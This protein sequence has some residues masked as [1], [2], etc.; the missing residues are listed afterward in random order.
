MDRA[1]RLFR[2]WTPQR[3]SLTIEALAL[4]D[5][6]SSGATQALTVG[7]RFETPARDERRGRHRGRGADPCGRCGVRPTP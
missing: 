1:L 3:A 4:I 7:E 2:G 5:V 6:T